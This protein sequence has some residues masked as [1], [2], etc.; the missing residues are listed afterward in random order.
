MKFDFAYQK[1]LEHRK[2]LEEI[3]QRD[4][5]E[6]MAELN[7]EQ[8]KLDKMNEDLSQAH[9]QVK[10]ET[11]K[12]GA[13]SGALKSIDE[14]IA[15][16]KIRISRQKEKVSQAQSLVESQREILRVKAIDYKIIEKLKE[17]YF[18][19]YKKKR[20]KREIKLLD[21]MNTMRFKRG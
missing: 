21:D 13:V 10:I 15:G 18:E 16:Q 2:R 6:A 12:S 4:F 3:A 8:S 9:V 5:L 1:V 11:D 20:R 17:K 7:L 14:F 19:D